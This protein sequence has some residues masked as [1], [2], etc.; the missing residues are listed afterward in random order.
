MRQPPYR[1]I[2]VKEVAIMNTSLSPL[3]SAEIIAQEAYI[4][5]YP[6]IL[7]DVTRKQLINLDPKLSPMGGTANA[8]THIRAFPTA[9]MRAV[10]RPNFDTLY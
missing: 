4:Y 1:S 7:M 5:L 6:L 10:V 9:E 3:G 2:P 8:F